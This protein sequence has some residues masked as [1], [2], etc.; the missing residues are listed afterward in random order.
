MAT[1]ALALL[2][3]CVRQ[4]GEPL[5]ASRAYNQ[6]LPELI[7]TR[8][9]DTTG[10]TSTVSSAGKLHQASPFRVLQALTV[11]SVLPKEEVRLDHSRRFGDPPRSRSFP[12]FPNLAIV[13]RNL[14]DAICR[15]DIDIGVLGHRFGVQWLRKEVV[16]DD[17][18]S[19]RRV[20]DFHAPA[21]AQ[22]AAADR[23]NAGAD[24]SRHFGLDFLEQD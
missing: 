24:V 23:P 6:P 22:V 17:L 13:L 20:A 8:P 18:A 10:A 11:W 4:I 5:W 14:V 2:S 21:V 15:T 9:S 19:R 16:P 12:A 3:S 1:D 7:N